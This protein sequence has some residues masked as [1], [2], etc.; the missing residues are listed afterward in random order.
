MCFPPK[1][2]EQT[3]KK[4][5]GNNPVDYNPPSLSEFENMTALQ[6]SRTFAPY[7]DKVDAMKM[8]KR[9]EYDEQQIKQAFEK[10]LY[11]NQNF[12]SELNIQ[13]TDYPS[14]QKPGEEKPYQ[15]AQSGPLDT[16]R[17]GPGGEWYFWN[18]YDAPREAVPLKFLFK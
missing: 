1:K 11:L 5:T 13:N 18:R 14:V 4:M 17:W 15:D 6:Q 8:K 3:K 12:N 10:K 16:E 9:E 2:K 7:D